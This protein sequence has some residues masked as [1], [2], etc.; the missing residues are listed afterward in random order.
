VV[1]GVER[2]GGAAVDDDGGRAVKVG[3]GIRVHEAV[4]PTSPGC[5]T[6]TGKGTV[7]ATP[8]QATVLRAAIVSTAAVTAGTVEARRAGDVGEA[9]A[10]EPQEAVEGSSSSSGVAAGDV[11]ARGSLG[12]SGR[13]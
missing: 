13:S 10:I 5:S 1:D 7:P 6:R 3:R 11:A 2:G 4:R 12:P 8:S 9:V